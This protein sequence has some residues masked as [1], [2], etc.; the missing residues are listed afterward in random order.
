MG[1]IKRGNLS[2]MET[3]KNILRSEI[4]VV[5]SKIKVPVLINQS[6]KT[7]TKYKGTDILEI[8]KIK[9]TI[10]RLKEVLFIMRKMYKLQQE[11]SEKYK[12]RKI[13]QI[14]ITSK[15]KLLFVYEKK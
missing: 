9:N 14:H 11:M 4:R 1:F 2:D 15:A 8:K 13:I 5:I 7:L 6:M 10:K 3:I 12:E